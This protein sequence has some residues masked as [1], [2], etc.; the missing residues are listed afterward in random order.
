MDILSL[1]L[2]KKK[3]RTQ[4]EV[5]AARALMPSD[6]LRKRRLPPLSHDLLMRDQRANSAVARSSCL[7]LDL[8][9]LESC[10]APRVF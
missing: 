9:A 8:Q 1:A 4:Q 2:E 10:D 3:L 5:R 7:C 6:M